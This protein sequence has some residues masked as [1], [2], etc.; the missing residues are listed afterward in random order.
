MDNFE[1]YPDETSSPSRDVFLVTPHNTN[2]LPQVPKA[3]RA[4]EAGDIVLRAVDSD[5]DVTLTV[6]AGEVLAI[7]AQFIR[8]T[9]TTV[10]V[11]HG[12]A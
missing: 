3:I 9:G 11:I 12:L 5:A 10:T 7:R 1:L 6:A 2:E 4:N 8:A